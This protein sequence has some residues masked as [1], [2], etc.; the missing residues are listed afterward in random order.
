MRPFVIGGI[1]LVVLITVGVIL[2]LRFS[3]S[4][5]ALTRIY[6]PPTE[7]AT[8]GQ[9]ASFQLEL[10]NTFDKTVAENVVME[11][12]YPAGI[13]GAWAKVEW[14]NEMG[15]TIPPPGVSTCGSTNSMLRCVLE[16]IEPAQTAILEIYVLPGPIYPDQD[17]ITPTTPTKANS[18]T[19]T[20]TAP[21]LQ[22]DNTD[23][24]TLRWMENGTYQE[25]LDLAADHPD[26][27]INPI[28]AMK[29]PVSGAAIPAVDIATFGLPVK[30]SLFGWSSTQE[31]AFVDLEYDLPSGMRFASIPDECKQ[32][33][34]K[35]SVLFCPARSGVPVEIQ[36]IPLQPSSGYIQILR[37]KETGK[38]EYKA[39]IV[40]DEKVPSLPAVNNQMVFNGVDEWAQLGY[41][42]LPDMQKFTVEMWVTPYS[43][44]DGQALIG[45]HRYS[46]EKQVVQ[47]LLVVGYYNGFINVNVLGKS[48]NFTSTLESESPNQAAPFHLAVVVDHM[49][50]GVVTV[51]KNGQEFKI[52]RVG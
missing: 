14:K 42:G 20:P 12:T 2:A 50:N 32:Q 26:L 5:A 15:I 19:G 29:F 22:I 11:Y 48:Q 34:G 6:T 23:R 1:V 24:F 35:Y 51:Y 39:L 21:A 44:E 3:K 27:T 41:S 49:N 9:P 13:F 10:K 52:G 36:V 28:D 40:S 30:I 33:T 43:L 17:H 46:K 47:N 18:S 38:A 4:P 37:G 25:D 45:A 16:R 8:A 7:K 31:G